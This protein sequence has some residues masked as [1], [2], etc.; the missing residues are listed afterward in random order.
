MLRGARELGRLWY[1]NFAVSSLIG[2]RD[3]STLYPMLDTHLQ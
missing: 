2:L 1:L 3:N